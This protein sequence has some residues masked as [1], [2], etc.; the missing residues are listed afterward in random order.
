[1]STAE[2]TRTGIL[3]LHP[4]GYGFLR[5]PS[6]NYKA[7]QD[8][9]YVGTLLLSRFQLRAGVRLTG[10]IEPP[11]NGQGPRLAEL[12]EIEGLEPEQYLAV[13]GFEDLTAIDP[14]VRIR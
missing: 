2:S 12:T 9:V 11:R 3:E 5:D 1:M 4:K 13:R 10:R 8:D 14:Y 6:R 7:G